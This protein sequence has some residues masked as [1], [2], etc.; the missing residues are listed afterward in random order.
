MVQRCGRDL[1]GGAMLPFFRSM[2]ILI[3]MIVTC[4]SAIMISLTVQALFGMKIGILSANLSTIVFV[5][6]FSHL[7]YM[8]SNW[9]N[10]ANRRDNEHSHRPFA[11]RLI[12]QS[13][14]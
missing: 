6:T 11:H 4:I 8:T 9:R 12:I 3:G 13:C 2:R 1:F 14:L 7:V 10:L 5:L